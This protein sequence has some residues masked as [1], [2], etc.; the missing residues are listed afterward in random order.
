MK[1]NYNLYTKY[2]SILYNTSVNYDTILI[3]EAS[4]TVI[5]Y[6]LWTVQFSTVTHAAQ[7]FHKQWKV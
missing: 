7:A 6:N 4:F 2:N 3:Q 1:L 5:N